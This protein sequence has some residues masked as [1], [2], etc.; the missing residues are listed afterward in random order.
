MSYGNV[1]SMALQPSRPAPP[2]PQRRVTDNGLASVGYSLSLPA[3]GGAYSG[4]GGSPGRAFD[5]GPPASAVVRQG[6]VQ[7]KEE[8]F[9]S[10][11][12]RPKF[13]VL[14]ETT[15]TLH[16]SDVGVFPINVGDY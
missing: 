9:A 5:G 6:T 14:K 13:L 4:I 15:L 12:W 11:L 16:K 3:P 10:F 2:A 8:G 7:V 1:G